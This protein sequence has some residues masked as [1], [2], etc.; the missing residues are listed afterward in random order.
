MKGLL[1]LFAALTLSVIS[2]SS[3]NTFGFWNAQDIP[4]TIAARTALY[5]PNQGPKSGSIT[6]YGNGTVVIG[7]SA[8][9]EV[10][11]MVNV[12][13]TADL[14]AEGTVSFG[15]IVGYTQVAMNSFILPAD[16]INSY[17]PS[18]IMLAGSDS[19]TVSSGASVILFNFSNFT[20][21]LSSVA[22]PQSGLPSDSA[23][24]SVKYLF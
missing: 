15:L 21:T 4:A 16:G 7:I 18:S 19:I 20:I 6:R 8:T 24:F 2:V 5:L 3:V 11:W 9:Y 17:M 23:T 14:P 22:N 12:A 10:D 13:L 1:I